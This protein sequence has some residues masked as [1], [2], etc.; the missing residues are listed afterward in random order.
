MA[1]GTAAAALGYA[2]FRALSPTIGD[3]TGDVGPED[4]LPAPRD[5]DGAPEDG[6]AVVTS[7]DVVAVTPLSVSGASVATAGLLWASQPLTPS[8]NAAANITAA[9]IPTAGV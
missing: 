5:T 3:E 7:G 8:I 2:E 6:A 9:T 1:A 4:G